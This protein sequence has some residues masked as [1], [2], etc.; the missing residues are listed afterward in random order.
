MPV[1]PA[2]LVLDM[3]MPGFSGLELQAELRRL[4][5]HTPIVFVSGESQ[6]QEIIDALTRGASHFLLKPFNMDDLLRAIHRGMAQDRERL[7]LYRNS[8]DVRL[9]YGT[10]TPREREVCQLVVKGLMN[11]E[12]AE[13]HGC[14]I[15][16]I[17]VHRARVMEKMGVTSLLTLAEAVAQ[18]D[19]PA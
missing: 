12:I 7:G 5:R 18:L 15:K 2:V 17:K 8:I 11:K 19:E 1:A 4:G 3:R 13:H 16:T 10:L 14:S 9:R 6:P